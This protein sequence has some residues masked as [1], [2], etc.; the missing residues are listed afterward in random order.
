MGNNRNCGCSGGGRG[1]GYGCLESVN[2]RFR[3]ENYPYYGGVCPDAD[4][5]YDGDDDADDRRCRRRWKDDD[6]CCRRRCDRDPDDTSEDT[7]DEDD[8]PRCRRRRKG[9]CR[10]AYGMFLANLPIAVAAN[11]IV[12]LVNA[13]SR[14]SRAQ[15]EANSGIIT[16]RRGG[17]YLVTY[18]IRVPEGSTLASTFTLNVNDAS[19]P[20]A[21]AIVGGM[22]PTGTTAQAIVEVCDRA[23]LTLRS[24]EAINLTETSMQPLVTLSAV[25]ID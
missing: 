13:S 23:T 20:S 9:C 10:Y 12:P 8:E 11:G 4:G 1:N 18:T 24:S 5:R 17:V 16:L 2:R 19:Q 14:D 25:Q 7:A 6:D 15:I 3:W 21:L 22:G